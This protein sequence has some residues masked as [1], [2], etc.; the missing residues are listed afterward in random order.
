MQAKSKIDILDNVESFHPY[1]EIPAL[2]FE[3]EWK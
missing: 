1:L 3:K 2:R